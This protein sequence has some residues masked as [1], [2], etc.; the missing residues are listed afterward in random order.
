ME[1]LKLY[2]HVAD[3]W[4]AKLRDIMSPPSV[5]NLRAK[6]GGGAGGAE[7]MQVTEEEA[8][9]MERLLSDAAL[10]ARMAANG[11]AIRSR[12]GLR[13][14]ADVIERVAEAYAART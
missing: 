14:G 9:E 7:V 2:Q 13:V 1:L 12:D 3:T 6:G 11:E 10:R 5:G 4:H 8:T